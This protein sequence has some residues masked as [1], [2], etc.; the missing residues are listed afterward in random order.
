MAT[1]LFSAAS[2][3][4]DDT[5]SES[6]LETLVNALFAPLLTQTIDG[7]QFSA[8]NPSR[9]I[10][11]DLRVIVT[12]ATGGTTI[13]NPYLVKGFTGTSI[14]DLAD[15]VQAFITANPGYFFA[16][17]YY[18]QLQSERRS[19][20]YIALLVYNTNLADGT[21]N[22][23]GG[24]GGTPGGAAG[25]DLTGFYPNPLLASLYEQTTAVLAN[26]A[27]TADT[28]AIATYGDVF[29]DYT[30]VKGAVRYNE[31]IR[32]THDGTTPYFS[33]FDTVLTPGT[34]DVV[35]SVTLVGG[36]LRLV[37]T[38]SSTGWTI[39]LRRRVLGA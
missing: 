16:P 18:Q 14:G 33:A 36:N 29:W 27:N 9:S 21:A 32:A 2:Q 22:W 35:M 1:L 26:G 5:P 38:T 3:S 6:G 39:K 7:V 13:T 37:A 17:V 19:K 23:S 28:A 20:Q 10:G 24:G 12:Y 4:F 11:N 8:I 25:G 31:T 30:L 15:A 34:V